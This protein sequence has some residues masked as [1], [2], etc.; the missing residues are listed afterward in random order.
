MKIP[1]TKGLLPGFRQL[2]RAAKEK[3]RGASAELMA[4]AEALI[5]AQSTPSPHLSGPRHNRDL[6]EHLKSFIF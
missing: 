4:A 5:R 3:K 1:S 2:D 6:Q